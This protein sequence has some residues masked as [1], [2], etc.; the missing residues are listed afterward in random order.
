MR[1][2]DIHYKLDIM[3]RGKSLKQENMSLVDAKELFD[4]E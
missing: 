4:L 1:D 2:C 3:A